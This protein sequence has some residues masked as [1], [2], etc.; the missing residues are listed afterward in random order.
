M[1]LYYK[2]SAKFTLHKAIDDLKSTLQND[3]IMQKLVEE[4][5]KKITRSKL[6]IKQNKEAIKTYF[7]LAETK[8]PCHQSKICP[9]GFD[10]KHLL[11]MTAIYYLSDLNKYDYYLINY[12][13]SYGLEA[14]KIII[15]LLLNN[16]HDINMFCQLNHLVGDRYHTIATLKKLSALHR[17]QYNF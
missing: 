11:I 5:L 2:M 8:Y 17:V 13:F 16:I 4:L 6:I 3:Y 12:G 14:N 10:I 9:V 7:G 1:L 15:L